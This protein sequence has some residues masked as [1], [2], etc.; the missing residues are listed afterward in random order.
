MGSQQ[1]SNLGRRTWGSRACQEPPEIF[2]KDDTY[3]RT[4]VCRALLLFTVGNARCHTPEIDFQSSNYVL[5]PPHQTQQC[6]SRT[7]RRWKDLAESFPKTCGLVWE[8]SLALSNRA[9]N[10]AQ[11]VIYLVSTTVRKLDG[12]GAQGFQQSTSQCVR[13][14]RRGVLLV[15]HQTV[16]GASCEA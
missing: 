6:R 7:G 12:A 5:H 13:L 8:S 9:L 15:S 11:G 1:P 16:S 4:C 3:T 10:S 2:R 14:E